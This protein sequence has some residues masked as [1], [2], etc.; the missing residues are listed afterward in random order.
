MQG[1]Y[2]FTIGR[3]LKV[4]TLFGSSW[5]HSRTEGKALSGSG[6]ASD[7]QLN[8]ISGAA[9]VSTTDNY[10]KYRYQALFARVEL[11]HADKMILNLTGRRDG[12]F[13]I[14]TRQPIRQLRGSR[15]CLDIFQ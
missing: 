6:Y 13:T 1:E 14:R 2:A 9:T 10:S 7:I 12:S 3:G 5:Q 4:K 8:S 15:S 11:N